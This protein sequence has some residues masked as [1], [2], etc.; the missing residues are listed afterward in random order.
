MNRTLSLF[1]RANP[2]SLLGPFIGDQRLCLLKTFNDASTEDV[3]KQLDPQIFRTAR[4]N[5]QGLQEVLPDGFE[6]FGIG[7]LLESDNI[8][9]GFEIVGRG[10]ATNDAEAPGQM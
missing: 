1:K 7:Y 4:Q 8:E 9:N 2:N 5:Q 10:T 3:K 6:W